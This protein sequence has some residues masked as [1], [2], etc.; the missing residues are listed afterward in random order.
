MIHVPRVQTSEYIYQR[1]YMNTKE[2]LSELLQKI[3]NLEHHLSSSTEEKTESRLLRFTNEEILKMPKTFKREFR[4]RGGYAHIRK[5]SDDRY[6]E[7]YE[8]RYR[9]NGYNISASGRT[10]EIAK[11]NFLEKLKVAESQKATLPAEQAKASNVVP[12]SFSA[13]AEYYFENFYKRKVSSGTYQRNLARYKK[14]IKPYFGETKI[15]KILPLTCQTFIDGFILCKKYKTATEIRSL[16]NG[17]FDM[18]KRHGLIKQNP[19][20]IVLNV[21]YEKEHGKRLTKPEIEKLLSETAGTPFQTMFAVVLYTGLRPS[22]Y[23]TA[24]IDGNFIVSVN[25]KQK[26]RKV[27]YKK[28]PIAPQLKDYLNGVSSLH[29]YST[30]SMTTRLKK[31]LPNHKLYDLRTTFYSNCHECNIVEIAIKLFM[32][33]SLGALGDSYTDLSDD[34]L[35]KEG[36]K[37]KF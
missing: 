31:I 17:I 32:G 34:F 37:F 8:I 9:K 35:I 14:H 22:E 21:Q 26:D 6:N 2:A 24:R 1:C 10:I 36:Q 18:A 20:D 30:K 28:I 16:L 15:N 27:H 33:H 12:S 25:S 5:R 13:F 4:I 29:I 11:A 23:K 19:L 7:S 3:E